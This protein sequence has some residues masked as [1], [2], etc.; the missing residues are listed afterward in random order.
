MVSDR[1]IYTIFFILLAVSEIMR[2]FFAG[3]VELGNDEVYYL[4]Y[5]RFP[6]LSHFD[7]PPM[8]AWSSSF[9]P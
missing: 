7:H 8:W 9:S 3:F 2:A 1:R 5:A 4:T 6:A